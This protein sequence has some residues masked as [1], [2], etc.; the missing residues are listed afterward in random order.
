MNQNWLLS[1]ASVSLRHNG[2]H[3]QCTVCLRDSHRGGIGTTI[4]F[5]VVDTYEPIMTLG[6]QREFEYL[7]PARSL[8]WSKGLVDCDDRTAW[9]DSAA[10]SALGTTNTKLA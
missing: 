1:N 4:V 6:R 3:N 2:L 5:R 7:R 10:D 8:S 9:M